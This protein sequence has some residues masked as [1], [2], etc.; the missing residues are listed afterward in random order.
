MEML[1]LF[2]DVHLPDDVGVLEG[3]AGGVAI[4]SSVR[5]GKRFEIPLG[6]LRSA[7][8]RA[9]A[10]AGPA[11]R[12]I[13]LWAIETNP[14][15]ILS[16]MQGE[17]GPVEANEGMQALGAHLASAGCLYQPR[18]EVR[19]LA[20]GR[21]IKGSVIC[22]APNEQVWVKWETG[23]KP[24]LAPV[25]ALDYR[26][27][28]LARTAARIERALERLGALPGVTKDPNTWPTEVGAP[29]VDLGGRPDESVTGVPMSEYPNPAGLQKLEGAVKR[30]MES[31]YMI[32]AGLAEMEAKKNTLNAWIRNTPQDTERRKTLKDMAGEKLKLQQVAGQVAQMLDAEAG[33]M[34]EMGDTTFR[35]LESEVMQAATMAQDAATKFVVVFRRTPVAQASATAMAMLAYVERFADELLALDRITKSSVTELLDKW[36]KVHSGIERRR[37]LLLA[38][39]PITNAY[40]DQF[41]QTEEEAPPAPS[42]LGQPVRGQSQDPTAPQP[43]LIQKLGQWLREMWG[44]VQ[45]ALNTTQTAKQELDEELQRVGYA[46]QMAEAELRQAFALFDQLGAGAGGMGGMQ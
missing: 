24:G 15:D 35:V 30:N 40:A 12:A 28:H 25:A 27:T 26:Y 39:G 13:Q 6:E 5:T 37:E 45:R 8:P 20:Q 34:D 7:Q 23:G 33:V 38:T 41:Q 22:V 2:S 18:D 43:S 9:A 29:A 44:Q 1:P 11:E 42:E 46:R 4:V 10:Q 19:T 36:K 3:Y 21:R 17:F 31:L 14:Y 32:Q 16:V